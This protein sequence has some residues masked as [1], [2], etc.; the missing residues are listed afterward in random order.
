MTS[1]L[2]KIEHSDW[3]A[4]LQVPANYVLDDLAHAIIEAAGF[5]MDHAYGFY[6]NLKNSYRSKEEFTLFADMGED[7]KEGDL[8]V[9]HMPID[10]V[11]EPE[12][13]MLF[14]FDYGDDW[15]FI[16]TCTEETN[17]RAF[18]RPKLIATSGTPP[19]QYPDYE[20]E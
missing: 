6:D 18:K 15:Q 13:K 14:L 5:E 2:F 4:E 3:L 19:V 1:L 10:A 16:V 8:G 9:E 11:F 20:E 12:K 17:T 7:A